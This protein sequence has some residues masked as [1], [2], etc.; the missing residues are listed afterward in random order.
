M[1]KHFRFG[2]LETIRKESGENLGTASG[3]IEMSRQRLSRIEKG[4]VS[5]EIDALISLAE[6]YGYEL[7]MRL[8]RKDG[9]GYTGID[10]LDGGEEG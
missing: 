6:I 5:I 10:L 4:E 3:S 8:E 7:T 2:I 1:S 9:E